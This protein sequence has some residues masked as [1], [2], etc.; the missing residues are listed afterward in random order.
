VRSD[1]VTHLLVTFGSVF[2]IVDPFAALPI[3]IAMTGDRSAAEQK[4]IA[5][6]AA[7]TCLTVLL[8][9]GAAGS[10]IM[11]FFSISL[12]AF[13]IAGGI[14]LFGVGLEMLRAKPS[15][16]RSTA[17]E[18]TEAQ[19]KE[20]VAIIPLGLPLLAG[21]GA[22]ATV[23]VL[24]GKAETLPKRGAVFTSI[25]VVSIV[26]FAVLRSAT[27]VVRW[28]GKTG[29]NLIGRIMGLIL[30]ATAVQFVIDGVREAFPKVLG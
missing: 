13:K 4:R 28:L 25:V 18:E 15:S 17:E 22:I 27:F 9:F 20:D 24:A 11:S 8:V 10:L 12:P 29:I 16:T 14:L 19:Q 7:V 6:R 23:M 1:L 3:Y 5:L 21:P 30:A 26:T 2:A